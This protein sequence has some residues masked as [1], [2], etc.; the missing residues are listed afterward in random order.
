MPELFDSKYFR[1]QGKVFLGDRNATTGAPEGLMFVG[2]VSSADLTPQVQNEEHIESVTGSGGIGSSFTKSVE[3]QLS[4]T[5]HSIKPDHLAI[6]LQGAVT[7]KAGASVTD[8]AHVVKLGKFSRLQHNKISAVTVT[9]AG[10]TPTYVA[11]TDYKMHADEGLIEWLTGGTVTEDLAVLIDYT[12]AAQKHVS[13]N[14]QNVEKYLVFAGKNSANNSKMTRCEIYKLK[15]DP[16]V[17][18]MIQETH[19]GMQITGR[20]LL[21]SLRAAG[22]Q[23]FGWKIED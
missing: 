18:G 8:E 19:A 10:G 15:L 12:Y 23:F 3:Y 5:M 7:V 14:P 1:G 6:A 16:S 21:D 9:G 4:M 20:I 17:L 13:A 2:D 11:D 22:D